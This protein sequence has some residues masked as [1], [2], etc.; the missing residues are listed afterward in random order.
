MQCVGHI[1]SM[2][3]KGPRLKPSFRASDR[4]GNVNK[5]V[6]NKPHCTHMTAFRHGK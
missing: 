1:G 4:R 2:I 6:V 3:V 5:K